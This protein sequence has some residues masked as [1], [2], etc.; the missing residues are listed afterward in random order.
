M[1]SCAGTQVSDL[2]PLQ[3]MPLTWL[4]CRR[5]RI[6]DFTPLKDMPLQYFAFDFS[7]EQD[8][9]LLRSIKTLDTINDKPAVEFWKE[10][11]KNSG[12]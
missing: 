3:G 11:G 9:G 7:P 5:L 10:V 4:D 6:T 1:L 2:S 12:Q 8:T